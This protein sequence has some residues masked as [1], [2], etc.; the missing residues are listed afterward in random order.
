L[1]LRIFPVQDVPISIQ[2]S[3]M[4]FDLNSNNGPSQY[5]NVHQLERSKTRIRNVY[6]SICAQYYVDVFLNYTNV[7]LWPSPSIAGE[8]ES[9][10]MTENRSLIEPSFADAIAII[11]C[12]AELSEDK[13]RHWATS[14]RQVAKLLDKPLELM[15]ARYSAVRADLLH[16]HRLTAKTLQNHKSNVK[17][18]LLWLAREK[19]FPEHG[20]PLSP[21]WA[22]LRAKIKDGFV[23]SRLASFMRFCSANNVVP[24]DVDETI[25]DSFGEYRSHCGKP[26][27]DSVR[28]LLARAWNENVGIRPDCPLRPLAEPAVKAAA[29]IAWVAFPAGLRRDLEGY[30]RGLT[31]IR[32]SR[33]GQRIR[34]LKEA[35]IRTRQAEIQAA[36]RTAVKVGVAIESLNSLAA[37]LAP[38]VAEKVLNAYWERNGDNPKLYTIDLAA[39]FLS[40]AHETKCLSDEDC[41]RLNEIRQNLEEKRPEGLTDKNIAFLRQVLSPGVWRRIVELPAVLMAEARRDHDHA[42]LRAAVTA[43]LAA[44]VAMLSVAPVRIANLTAIQLGKNLSKPDG[45]NSNYWLHF[46]EH[47][48][49]NR[50][51][52]MFRLE[53]FVTRIIDEYVHEFRPTLLRGR[54]A[55]WLFPGLRDGPKGKVAFSGQ[56]ADRIWKHTGVRTT[57]HQFR[58]AA[59]ALIL[60]RR[61]GDYELV[62]Q[63]LG[64]RNVQTTID[65]YIGLDMIQASQ[66]YAEIVMQHL[67]QDLEAAE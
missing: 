32:K 12:A 47:D 18:A 58:H 45:P 17:S 15:P 22:E 54:D 41:E 40:I 55:D 10:L 34:P 56:I 46:P 38:D 50:M 19:G 30:L 23:R 42:P 28:R 51:R 21:P 7:Y 8:E 25:V 5:F 64:H 67:D 63:L 57:V 52:L 35:T 43:Q 66:I 20:A 31:K 14:L 36:A 26:V 49:K 53:T 39:R 62:R 48:V 13:R 65:C 4:A 33:R 24:N 1:G 29:D 2:Q 6:Q 27:D 16:L 44:A 61:P 3:F 11:A 60:K 9:L 59:G 37:L